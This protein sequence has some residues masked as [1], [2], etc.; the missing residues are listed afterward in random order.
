MNCGFKQLLSH[1]KWNR[2]EIELSSDMEVKTDIADV[3]AIHAFHLRQA[4]ECGDLQKAVDIMTNFIVVISQ[5]N[6]ERTVII[7]LDSQLVHNVLEL[8]GSSYD[9]SVVV[10]CFELISCLLKC[11]AKHIEPFLGV[12]YDKSNEVLHTCVNCLVL[13][14][15]LLCISTFACS[16]PSDSCDFPFD[17][18]LDVLLIIRDQ[19]IELKPSLLDVCSSIIF[20]RPNCYLNDQLVCTALELIAEFNETVVPFDDVDASCFLYAVKYLVKYRCSRRMELGDDLVSDNL[21]CLLRE[22]ILRR[23]LPDDIVIASMKL[24]LCLSKRRPK[25]RVFLNS[26]KFKEFADFAK[27]HVDKM[28]A[29]CY[30]LIARALRT[31]CKIIAKIFDYE[32]NLN[33]M[34]DL[35][36]GSY[37]LRVATVR[38]ISK[39]LKYNLAD[40]RV[41]AFVRLSVPYPI[42]GL[43]DWNTPK[44]DKAI[45][46]ILL[47][48]TEKFRAN[49]SAELFEAVTDDSFL[50]V[51][52]EL[53]NDS[54][55]QQVPIMAETLIRR[56]DS[57]KKEMYLFI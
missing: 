31:K 51:L 22:F 29:L 19:F 43:L 36:A 30:R 9:P 18:T 55:S 27:A 3:F 13:E 53:A 38:L 21:F 20:H 14:K 23:Y 57:L 35:E 52:S 1:E 5:R 8:L 41:S 40:A 24:L 44:L 45:F 25:G 37:E 26:I 39:M 32:L 33:F 4:C 28:R 10:T 7:A 42:L 11:G 12:V 47:S 50:H 54:C 16:L 56:I 17:T 6:D 48:I 2:Y 34:E 15:C 49:V 46:K